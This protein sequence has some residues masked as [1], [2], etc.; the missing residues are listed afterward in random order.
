MMM[1]KSVIVFVLALMMIFVSCNGSPSAS[2][3]NPPSEEVPSTPVEPETPAEPEEPEVPAEPSFG[4]PTIGLNGWVNHGDYATAALTMGSDWYSAKIIYTVDG[5]T[6]SETNGM[7]FRMNNH[8]VVCRSKTGMQ[9]VSSG[10]EVMPNCTVK[11]IAIYVGSY[12]DVVSF[13]VPEAPAYA[14]HKY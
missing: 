9:Y 2:G 5:S 3:E 4:T 10:V 13:V 8:S 6:P 12:S 1:K 11:A 7:D 14:L